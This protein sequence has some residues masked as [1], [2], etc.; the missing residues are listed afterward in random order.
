[1][2]FK[3]FIKTD[4][5]LRND[6]NATIQCR[7]ISYKL[8]L[9]RKLFSAKK[10]ND[11]STCKLKKHRPVNRFR[12]PAVPSDLVQFNGNGVQIYNIHNILFYL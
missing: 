12:A 5:L 4:V 3:P 6:F 1:M 8:H 11:E 10:N 7:M 2:L 9:S